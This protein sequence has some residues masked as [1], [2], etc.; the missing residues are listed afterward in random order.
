M[1]QQ[2]NLFNPVFRRKGFSFTSATAMLYGTGIAIAAMAIAGVVADYDLRAARTTAAAA[3]AE[4]RA[5]VARRDALSA[6]VAQQKPDAS[7]EKELSDL[8]TTLR[9]RQEIVETLK[10][11]AIGNTQGFSDYMLAFSRQSVSGLWLTGFDIALAGNELAI[12]GRTLSADLVATY[13]A[14][15]NDEKALSG[16][17]F[18]VMRI[19]RQAQAPTL[20][21]DSAAKGADAAKGEVAGKTPAAKPPP[22][23]EFSIS[24]IDLPVPGIAAV[25]P[26]PVPAPLLGTINASTA[27]DAA[28]A[29]KTAEAQK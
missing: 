28:K 3:N 18:G 22:Y 24:T 25:R 12:Q 13:L 11:G 16:R 10:S 17:Q 6:E 27:L 2:I 14:R 4:Y 29:A 19:N 8:D 26:E 20:A 15:L 21:V 7:L 1:S 5:A 9:S 23:L